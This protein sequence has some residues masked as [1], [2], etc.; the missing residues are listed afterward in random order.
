MESVEEPP[1]QGEDRSSLQQSEA[2]ESEK[3]RRV[4][5]RRT[6]KPRADR[7]NKK[8]HAN[9]MVNDSETGA[10]ATEDTSNNSEA[11]QDTASSFGPSS[12]GSNS[13]SSSSDDESSSSD[14]SSGSSSSTASSRHRRRHK[15]NK[16]AKTSKHS[17]KKAKNSKSNSKSKSRSS[18][19]R[20]DINEAFLIGNGFSKSH[21][22][23]SD[24]H[25]LTAPILKHLINNEWIKFSELFKDYRRRGGAKDLFECISEQCLDQFI[26]HIKVLGHGTVSMKQLPKFF[27]RADI[28]SILHKV[29]GGKAAKA[30]RTAIQ[31]EYELPYIAPMDLWAENPAPIWTSKIWDDRANYYQGSVEGYQWA[32]EAFLNG[33]KKNYPDLKEKLTRSCIPKNPNWVLVAREVNTAIIRHFNKIDNCKTRLRDLYKKGAHQKGLVRL[34]DAVNFTVLNETPTTSEKPVADPVK[35]NKQSFG[36]KHHRKPHTAPT[37]ETKDT[38]TTAATKPDNKSNQGKYGPNSVRKQYTAE[39]KKAYAEK[40]AAEAKKGK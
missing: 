37:P 5:R 23:S 17:H 31:Q 1:I 12:D 22:T 19:S 29:C 35:E 33:L 39:E 3:S 16:K 15:S 27:K 13:S 9:N 6:Y 34:H 24:N 40:K 38:S 8:K 11:T 7:S 21:T 30:T 28:T 2:S 14:D 20:L 4:K 10:S 25:A 32:T 26:S 18:K 36:K